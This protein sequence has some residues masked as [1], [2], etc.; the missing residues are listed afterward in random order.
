MAMIC[1]FLFLL[2]YLTV[3]VYSVPQHWPIISQDLV[4][5]YAEVFIADNNLFRH[6]EN[7]MLKEMDVQ[8]TLQSL[9][10]FTNPLGKKAISF[11]HYLTS[12]FFFYTRL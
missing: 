10:M 11:R 1:A 3:L 4:T 5:T 6:D 2:A 9:N 12:D 8:L 7:E